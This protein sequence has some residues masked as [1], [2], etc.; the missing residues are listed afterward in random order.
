MPLVTQGA[1]SNA[2]GSF[3]ATNG[4]FIPQAGTFH[5]GPDLDKGPSSLALDEIF[6]V[7][8]LVDLPW[9]FQISGIFRA[10]SGFHFSKFD[11]ASIDHD[12][13]GNFT[14]ID[15]LSGRNRFTAPPYVTLDTRF[16]KRFDL[17]ERVKIQLLL[18][19]FN[20]LNRQNA[21]AVQSRAD[22]P[23]RPTLRPF[24]TA[25]QVLPGREGQVGV[26]ISF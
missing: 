19:F 6:Q 16:S 13:N 8:G 24:G 22:S 26:R 17:G 25:D 10:Q 20:L 21:A 4:R 5:N 14:G 18:E 3:T 7:N 9:Q 15:V 12:G 1:N 23:L 2:N 11:E